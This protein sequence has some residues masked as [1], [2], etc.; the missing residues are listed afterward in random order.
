MKSSISRLTDT[1]LHVCGLVGM[2]REHVIQLYYY[3]IAILNASAMVQ[4][5]TFKQNS[6]DDTKLNAKSNIIL[7]INYFEP[8]FS[9]VKL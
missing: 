4:F 6:F 2:I 9:I 5:F 3:R 1:H 8:T 7:T